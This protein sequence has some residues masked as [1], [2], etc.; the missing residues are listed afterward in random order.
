MYI[1]GHP[2]TTT[3][4]TDAWE[5]Y[6]KAVLVAFISHALSEFHLLSLESSK[7][8]K[9]AVH[10]DYIIVNDRLSDAIDS[11]RSII[12]AKRILQGRN[13]DGHPIKLPGSDS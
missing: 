9:E 5:I 8:I 3:T 13:R 2:I 7:E 6:L 11:L 10:Y 12:I 4:T 1:S